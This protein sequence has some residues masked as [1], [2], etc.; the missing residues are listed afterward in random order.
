MA[1]RVSARPPGR[2][3]PVAPRGLGGV[4]YLRDPAAGLETALNVNI[5]EIISGKVAASVPINLADHSRI[6]SETEFYTAAW[7][8]AVE[9]KSVDPARREEYQF[10]VVL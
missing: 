2:G 6:P 8:S 4:A 9:D 10:K 5:I 3:D 1:R 7:R